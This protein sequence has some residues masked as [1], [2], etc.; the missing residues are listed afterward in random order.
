MARSMATSSIS[1]GAP[2]LETGS[3]LSGEGTAKSTNLPESEHH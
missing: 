1:V 2:D 3:R